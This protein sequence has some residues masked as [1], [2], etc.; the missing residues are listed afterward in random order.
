MRARR[1][2]DAGVRRRSSAYTLL[3]GW[4]RYADPA[5]AT[6]EPPVLSWDSPAPPAPPAAPA[7]PAPGAA[8]PPR[9]EQPQLGPQPARRCR[10]S[11][12]SRCRSSTVSAAVAAT[13]WDSTVGSSGSCSPTSGASC[14]GSASRYCWNSASTRGASWSASSSSPGRLGQPLD[15]GGQVGRRRPVDTSAIRNRRRPTVTM[16]NRPSGSSVTWRS[17]AVQPTSCSVT[18]ALAGRSWP[19]RPRASVSQP[20]PDRDHAE[21]AGLRRRAAP[22]VRGPASR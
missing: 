22:S 4:S 7:P 8:A 17:S 6:T 5:Q 15:L 1:R 21:L 18:A 9:G 13:R 12:S 2:A 20:L 16:S 3:A 10:R 19:A 14:R 11:A